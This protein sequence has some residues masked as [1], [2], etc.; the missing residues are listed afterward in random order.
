M[1]RVS[2]EVRVFP[3]YGID[4]QQSKCFNAM[5]KYL[6]D[7]NYLWTIETNDYHIWKDGN[8]YL[9]IINGTEQTSR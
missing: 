1:L 8:K 3:L 2:N 4:G 9:K 6:S 7:N 5:T